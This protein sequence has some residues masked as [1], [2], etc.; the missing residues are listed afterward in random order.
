MIP[1][2]KEDNEKDLTPTKSNPDDAVGLLIDVE[3]SP[4]SFGTSS[5]ASIS[6]N[7]GLIPVPESLVDK[8]KGSE[9]AVEINGGNF[10]WDSTEEATLHHIQLKIKKGQFVVIVGA[11]GSGKSSIIG[12]KSFV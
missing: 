11:V 9:V 4:T 8:F 3:P 2:D 12:G 10:R 5:A 1:L 6:A 7:G